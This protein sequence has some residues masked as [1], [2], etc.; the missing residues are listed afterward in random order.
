MAVKEK[1]IKIQPKSSNDSHFPQRLVYVELYNE[2]KKK[3]G[4]TISNMDNLLCLNLYQ[5]MF[6]TCCFYRDAAHPSVFDLK[7]G[8]SV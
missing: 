1:N 5:Q 7:V 6:P 8:L 2:T 4:T 3:K